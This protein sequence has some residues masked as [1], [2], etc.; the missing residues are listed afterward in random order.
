MR[1]PS[2]GPEEHATLQRLHERLELHHLAE[3]STGSVPAE[4]IMSAVLGTM[5]GRMSARETMLLREIAGLARII[6]QAKSEIADVSIGEIRGSHIPSAAGELDAIVEHTAVA[7][8]SILEGCEMLDG[9]AGSLDA[10][11]A[12]VVQNVTTRIYEACSFQDI[13]GQRITKVVKALK[14]IEAKVAMLSGAGHPAVA[15]MP[16]VQIAIGPASLL[17]GPMLPHEAMGQAAIDALL[18]DFD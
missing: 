15:E 9:L 16:R 3:P 4:D 13:T 12:A 1:D 6:E 10:K 14:A 18:A 2:T 5:S 7:T 17:N 11:Q 8:Q